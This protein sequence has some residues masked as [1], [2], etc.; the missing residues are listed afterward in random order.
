L[1]ELPEFRSAHEILIQEV[2][3]IGRAARFIRPGA[4]MTV[5]AL[6]SAE[7]VIHDTAI[8]LGLRVEFSSLTLAYRRSGHPPYCSIGSPDC[9]HALLSE[10]G[11]LMPCT[12]ALAWGIRNNILEK[13]LE[14]AWQDFDHLPEKIPVSEVGGACADCEHWNQ[15]RGGCRALNYAVT[16]NH[17]EPYT[18]CP[19]AQKLSAAA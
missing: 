4:A 19:R 8:S 5:A 13:G 16:G 14:Q 18:L 15:C 10:T 7:K 9:V 2:V 11:D 12:F 6:E 17:H 1:L 3:P